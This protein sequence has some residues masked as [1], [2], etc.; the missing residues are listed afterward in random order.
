MSEA[1]PSESDNPV[2]NAPP[3]LNPPLAEILGGE[4]GIVHRLRQFKGAAWWLPVASLVLLAG[5]LVF[6]FRD[7]GT[8][9]LLHFTD[10]YGLKVGDAVRHRGIDLGEVV[11]VALSPDLDAVDV[12]VRLLPH[13]SS[14][15]REGTEFW[16]ERPR[17]SLAR[18][19][20]L[21][22]VV[23]AKY[24][25]VLPG[26]DGGSPRVEFQGRDS[27]PTLLAGG[28]AE[29]TIQFQEGYSLAV[30]DP[31]KY[32][33]IQLGE[34]VSLD[35]ASDLQGITVRVRLVEGGVHLARAGSLFWIE[36]PRLGLTGTRGLETIV[37][38]RYLAVRPGPPDAAAETR[39]VGEELPAASEE[40]EGGL[41]V[42]LEAPNRLGIEV[43]SPLVYRGLTIGNVLSVKL[44]ANA[45]RVEVRAYITSRYKGL[46]RDNSKFWSTSG[47]DVDIGLTGVKV[48]AETLATIASGGVSLATPDTPGK[49]VH[50][51][52][53]FPLHKTAEDEWQAWSPNLLVGF[54]LAGRPQPQPLRAALRWSERRLGFRRERQR[55]GWLLAL[56]D[57]RL[58]GPTDLLTVPA[59]A[60]DQSATLEVAGTEISL[61]EPAASGGGPVSVLRAEV[62]AAAEHVWPRAKLRV[63]ET[64]EDCLIFPA[65]DE[66]TN[67]LSSSS[68][69]I[70]SGSDVGGWTLDLGAPVSAEMHGGCAV[71]TQD[72]HVIGILVIDGKQRNLVPLRR[73]QIE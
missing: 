23:G 56:S 52:H 29:I 8:L 19:S 30:G 28:V 24:I 63:A 3:P 18:T 11:R 14:L 72:G 59:A 1:P 15:A 26:P 38:G 67:V 45:A 33:G 20:G 49:L 42:V 64:R 25:N 31:L 55:S 68:F 60:I 10:G 7:R 5:V 48:N 62:V 17:L 57:G 69:A 39:F 16:I 54:G 41:E 9:V 32:R 21:D 22:T 51:G 46:V 66:G 65:P 61:R 50:T 47:L 12:R 34:V 44:A 73:E 35:M 36:R 6:A 37:G 43:G 13:A 40:A 27:P 53:R 58:I 2:Q 4:P 71:A 70:P